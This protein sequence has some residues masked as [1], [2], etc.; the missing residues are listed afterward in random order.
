MGH[1]A[2]QG[3]AMITVMDIPERDHQ[4]SWKIR[5]GE[6]TE[7]SLP[8]GWG[9][10]DPILDAN[11]LCLELVL[12]H[13]LVVA[14]TDT[15]IEVREGRACAEFGN[16]T[17]TVYN[18]Q[19]WKS[20]VGEWLLV[21]PRPNSLQRE[22]Q[23]MDAV[24]RLEFLDYPCVPVLKFH[25]HGDFRIRAGT[26]IGVARAIK[27]NPDLQTRQFHDPEIHR[28]EREIWNRRQQGE[29]P[30]RHYREAICSK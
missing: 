15:S 9:N 4:R 12:I 24:I 1:D 26:C 6:N 30:T 20:N 3:S 8:E 13:D 19:I 10:C 27:P 7:R 17:V 22:W 29:K 5:P 18:N 23:M 14:Y 2:F 25:Q 16:G 21:G 11:Q 28:K